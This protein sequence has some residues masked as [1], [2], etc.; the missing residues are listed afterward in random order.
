M[1]WRSARPGKG[2]PATLGQRHI[3]ILPTKYGLILACLLVLM[4]IGSLNYASNPGFLY[5]FLLAGAG[6]VALLHTWHNL[7]GLRVRGGRAEPVFAGQEAGFWIEL[8]N[9]RRRPRPGIEVSTRGATPQLIDLPS[10]GTARVPLRVPASRRGL[11]PLGR[12]TLSTRYP[13]GLLRAWAYVELPVQ[14]LVYP[15][16]AQAGELPPPAADGS[17]QGERGSGS[18]DFLGLRGYRPGDSPRQVFWKAAARG[19]ELLTKEFAGGYAE[20]LWL[21]WDLLPALETEPRL[22]LLCRLVL[23]AAEQ[24][25]SYGLRLPDLELGPGQGE[26]HRQRC[27]AALARFRQ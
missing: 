14:C 18:E 8:E 2:T 13:L 23:L 7:L 20:Q 9:P 4:L 6:L 16:P 5:T 19:G 21:D 15:K 27:L 11:L 25:R 26:Q 3:Y 17:Q 24:R 12:L 1:P 22:S 10:Q